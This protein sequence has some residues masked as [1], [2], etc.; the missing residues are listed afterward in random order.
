MSDLEQ[1]NSEIKGGIATISFSSAKGNSLPATLLKKLAE[2]IGEVS[3]NSDVRVIVLKSEGQGP[4]CGGASF[5]ELRRVNTPDQGREFFMG[6]ARLI[7]AMKKAPKFI[8][9]RV[10]GKAVGGGVGVVSASDY[11]LALNSAAIKLSELA[12]GIGPFVVGPAVQRK[13]GV[14]MFSSFAIDTDWRD[15]AW[16]K[17]AG[18]YSEV[19]DTLADLDAAVNN[20]ATKLA[21]FSPE[22]MA[23]LKA[24]LW[25]GTEHWDELLPKRA[26]ISGTLVLSDFTKKAIA[27]L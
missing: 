24:V 12:L 11:A 4:F 22:A 3:R 8:I 13:V 25:E 5:E 1:V 20:L 2:T 23:K 19:F 17:T 7:L 10:H 14:A 16:G 6:F 21:A 27:A 26:E 9:T 18:L 15:A